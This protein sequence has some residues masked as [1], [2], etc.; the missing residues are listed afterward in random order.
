MPLNRTERN[1]LVQFSGGDVG[2][3]HGLLLGLFL[4]S[5]SVFDFIFFLIFSFLGRA[6]D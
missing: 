3:L 4:L 2:C 6:L 1:G 5:N